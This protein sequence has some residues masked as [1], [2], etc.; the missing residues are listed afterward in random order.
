MPTPRRS[1]AT[2]VSSTTPFA[3]SLPPP[4]RSKPQRRKRDTQGSTP[5]FSPMPSRAKRAMSPTSTLRWLARSRPA[6]APSPGPRCC[7]RAAKP[8]SP[9]AA[10]S[11]RPQCRVPARF[12]LAIDGID[13]ITALAADTDGID[14]TGEATPAPARTAPPPPGCATR[15]SIRARLLAANDTHAA[16]A[17][18]ATCRHRPDRHQR[19]RLPRGARRVAISRRRS[20]PPS[21]RR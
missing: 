10:W 11:R 14:G 1:L 6:I 9:S 5:T 13:G 8:L 20:V 7:C 19:Q 15:A 21:P 18:S 17:A 3:S 4:C 12:A 2:L 16:F